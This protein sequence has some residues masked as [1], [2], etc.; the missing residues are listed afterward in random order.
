MRHGLSLC[1]IVKNEEDWAAGAIESVRTIIDEVI[2]VDTGSTDRTVDR[3]RLFQPV[4]VNR[5]WTQHFA[6]ARNASL[7][8]AQ[9]AYEDCFLQQRHCL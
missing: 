8:A 2:F 1:T 7:E 4:I 6:K 3:V 9:L 5:A